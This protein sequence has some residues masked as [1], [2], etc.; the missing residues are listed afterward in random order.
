MKKSTKILL[1]GGLACLLIGCMIVFI[2]TIIGGR[3]KISKMV[4]NGD[5]TVQIGKATF[6]GL[7]PDIDWDIEDYW[8]FN[9]FYDYD[10]D[11][12]LYEESNDTLTAQSGLE[13]IT[14]IDLK[15]AGGKLKIKQDETRDK[16]GFTVKGTDQYKTTVEN[17]CL[18]IEP[19]E[20][21]NYVKKGT[22]ITIYMPEDAKLNSFKLELGGG[23]ADISD[24]VSDEVK[25]NIGAGELNINKINA[26]ELSCDIGAGALNIKNAIVDDLDMEA[27]MG[28]ANYAGEI[29]QE[30][31]IKCSMGA[32]DL[33]IDG[34][35]KDFNYDLDCAMGTLNIEGVSKTAG[36]GTEKL[37]NNGADK[38]IE[39][40]CDVGT[41]AISFR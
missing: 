37:I 10:A 11:D 17:G 27:S 29:N 25:I 1:G 14:E 7:I 12:D 40:R 2:T 3:E 36:M 34:N 26:R 20:P 33:K 31:E 39:V 9:G 38:E 15:I 41:V 32:V 21:I 13:D 5:F 23:K 35:D 24:I 28:K 19:R 4:R 16:Y 30:A 8:I 22:E 18:K 6:F